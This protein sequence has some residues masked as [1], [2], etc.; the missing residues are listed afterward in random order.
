MKSYSRRGFLKDSLAGLGFLAGGELLLSNNAV[1]TEW[2]GDYNDYIALLDSEVNNNKLLP[3]EWSVTEDN[4]KGPFYRKGSPFRAKIS[5]PLSK[6]TTLV[7]TGRVWGYDTKKTLSNTVLDIW[8]ADDDGHYDNDGSGKTP[9]IISSFNRARLVTDEN[10]Y[11]EY[12]TIHPG[13]Y[14][15]SPGIWRPSHIHYMVRHP[16]Y[17]DLITQLYFSGDH[18]QD[19]DSIIKKSLII[20]LTAVKKDNGYFQKGNFDI[21]LEPFS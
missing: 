10:G 8:H 16:G 5:P 2:N 1:P 13:P 7:I 3:D 11:Y 17:N 14:Q 15:L 4:V 19:T 12:E 21:I 18:Y 20:D 6:G 9:P